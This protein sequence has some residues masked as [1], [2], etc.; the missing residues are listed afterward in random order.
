MTDSVESDQHFFSAWADSWWD[1][2]S[3]M[4][5]L[6]SF[7][8]LRFAYFDP[9]AADGWKGVR[10]L[11]VGC[12]GGYTTE[13][14][15]ARGSVV[16]GVDVSPKLVAAARQHAEQTGKDIDYRVG[17]AEAL[18]F[19]DAAF[20]IVT[21]VDVLEHVQSPRA[22]VAEIH[23]VLRPGGLFM[24]DTINRTFMSRIMMIWLPERVL[25]I[26]P[27]GAHDWN[28]FIT[29]AEMKG[30]L[31]SAGF[32]PIGAAKGI[33]IRGQNKDGSLRA[34]LTSDTSS[35]YLGVARK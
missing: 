1:T 30:Y 17:A 27:K 4:N 33:A 19:D 21:C 8:P 14:L 13:F 32:A 20:D 35:L 23:R 29:P 15:H 16:S 28:D 34:K 12:G 25:G 18:P 9:Y 24:Y 22:A 10:V 11:D 5:P 31:T 3:K 7:N 6:K 2:D 26:V